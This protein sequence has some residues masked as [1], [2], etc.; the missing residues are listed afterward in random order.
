M[1][2]GNLPDLL[3][4]ID[5]KTIKVHAPTLVVFVCGGLCGKVSEKPLSLRDAFMRISHK[6][7]LAKYR[8]I[9]AEDVKAFFPLGEYQELLKFESDIAQI[10]ELLL[11]FSESAG[12]LAELGV[13]AMDDE[14]APRMMVIVDDDNYKSPSFIKLG[15]LYTLMLHYGDAAVCVIV[16]AD[17]NLTNINKVEDIDLEKLRNILEEPLKAR[18]A[19]KR[20]PRTFNRQRHGHVTKL[21]TGL[22]QHYA[23]LTIEEIDVLLYCLD[24]PTSYGD[25]R[26][27]ILC[28]ETFGWV[29]SEKRGVKTYYAAVAPKTALHFEFATGVA[30]LDRRRWRADIIEYWKVAEPERFGVISVAAVRSTK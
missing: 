17:V 18:L 27:H 23:A 1:I 12:S 6:S 4:Y 30:N 15:P 22:I 7:P 13:F 21:I 3:D 26:K 28:A 14:V 19:I 5:A 10:S 16:L 24:V 9:L 25:I 11:L 8:L 20:E 2:A 29:L